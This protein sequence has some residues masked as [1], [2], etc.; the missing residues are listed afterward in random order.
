MHPLPTPTW[1]S[2]AAVPIQQRGGLVMRSVLWVAAALLLTACGGDTSNQLVEKPDRPNPFPDYA[3]QMRYAK[4]WRRLSHHQQ[5]L[6]VAH[7]S[8]DA[9]FTKAQSNALIWC[10]KAMVE[11][12]Q[13]AT[14]N[15]DE[16]KNTCFEKA[17]AQPQ[18]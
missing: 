13:A 17:K 10:F 1:F 2:Y 6:V 9:G 5:A 14:M 15:F 3:R 8:H 16:A 11:S 12:D 4:D 18:S 7:W